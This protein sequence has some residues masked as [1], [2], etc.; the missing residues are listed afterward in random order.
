MK[1]II[2]HNVG[3][4]VKWLRML[5]Y[6]TVFFTGPDDWDMVKTALNEDR[7]L[8]TKDTGVMKRGVVSSG[9]VKA[10]FI[11]S[12]DAE[13]QVK[14][15]IETFHLDYRSGLFSRCMECNT[16]LEERSR[17]QVTDRVPPYVR[18]TQEEYMECPSCLRIY[19]KGTHW[20]AMNARLA[21]ISGE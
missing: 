13:E 11:E 5:G 18:K 15:V 3:K 4:L 17:E 19:W 14:Q 7:V 21:E 2:D 12:I 1:F 8:L 16:L 6:D 9:R 10:L 20:Q